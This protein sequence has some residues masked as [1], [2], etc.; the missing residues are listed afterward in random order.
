MLL[1][2]SQMSCIT[3]LKA[4]RSAVQ[5]R[6]RLASMTKLGRGEPKQL[7]LIEVLQAHFAQAAAEGE[8]GGV[9]RAIV[10]TT[11]RDSVEGICDALNAL[12]GE[13]ISARCGRLLRCA[14][15]AC[16]AA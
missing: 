9:S 12:E 2:H 8:A 13:C 14:E 16:C 1:R 10:F 4:P 3:A 7:K 5:L 6:G 11:L 15:Q